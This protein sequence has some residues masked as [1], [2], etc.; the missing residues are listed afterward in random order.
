MTGTL[1]EGTERTFDVV[2]LGYTATD[3]LAIVPNLPEFDTK[4]EATCLSIQGGGPVATGLVTAAR[5]GHSCSYIGKVGDDSFAEF[6][7][8]ELAR[9]GVDV[10]R[11]V[12]EKGAESQFAFVMVDSSSGHRTIVW[13]RGTVSKLRQGEAILTDIDS[14]RCLLLD[15]LEVEAAI[16]AALRAREAKVPIVLDAGTFREGMGKLLPLCDYIVAGREFGTQLAGTSAPLAA[17]R[18]IHDKTGNVAA[19][20]MGEEGCVCVDTDGVHRQGAFKV[21]AVDT[22]GAG[23]V[24]HGAFAVGILKGWE[25][26]KVLEFSSAVAAMKCRRLGGRPGIPSFQEAIGFLREH[27]PQNW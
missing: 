23:D 20:T 8:A 10:R 11:V 15:D 21:R 16:E 4:L 5:L 9:E 2:G 7:V 27:S 26:P 22:T 25:L 12:C 13:T 19:I 14:C 6:M 18:D 24:F 3:Y 1:Q 17:A